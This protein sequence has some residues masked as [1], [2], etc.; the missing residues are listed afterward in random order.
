MKGKVQKGNTPKINKFPK[1]KPTLQ[2]RKSREEE[3]HFD[4]MEIV[5]GNNSQ[6]PARQHK[7]KKKKK[8]YTDAV[9]TVKLRQKVNHKRSLYYMEQLILKH[10]IHDNYAFDVEEV[11][12]GC[13]FIFYRSNEAS[14]FIEFMTS[15]LPIRVVK[16]NPKD[17]NFKLEMAQISKYDVVCLPPSLYNSMGNFGPIIIC[18]KLTTS[19]YFVDPETLLGGEIPID[20]YF[21]KEKESFKSL[22][23]SKPIRYMVLEIVQLYDVKNGQFQKA[24][25]C[26]VKESEMG[27][28]STGVYVNTHLGNILQV[29][30]IVLGYDI[31]NSNVNDDNLDSYKRVMI[32]DVV[33]VRK[34]Y[35]RPTKRYW[36]LAK[37]KIDRE[38]DFEEF[39]EELEEDKEMRSKIN[40][41]KDT[42]VK[43]DLDEHMEKVK[44]MPH[45]GLE[46]LLENLKL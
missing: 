9:A 14:R 38:E 6:E 29:G 23:Q 18:Y 5:T 27:I 1:K 40:L 25:V 46:E 20:Q 34:V 8:E 30:D 31:K 28:D 26:V 7:K 16:K 19:L 41:Y 37:W 42:S 2:K 44:N 43:M 32:P 36:N 35:D 11:L 22:F 13:D 10:K 3:E 33:L 39:M 12:H 17:E 21:K 15:I 45:V 4:E 24:Q